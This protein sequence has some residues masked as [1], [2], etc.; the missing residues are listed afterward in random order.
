M[1]REGSSAKNMDALFNI[2]NRIKYWTNESKF[3]NISVDDY[4]KLLK[5]PI[6][7][8]LVSDDKNPIDLKN[9]HL[10]QLIK[11]AINYDIEPIE[12]IKMVTL[13]PANHYHLNSGEIS[14]GKKANF[15]LVNNLKDLN[16]KL[17]IVN[18]E[19]VAKDGKSLFKV[20]KPKVSN[21]FNVNLKKP[22]DFDIKT[23]KDNNVN[24]KIIEAFN[25]ELITNSIIDT[26][27]IENNIIISDTIKDI[28]KISVVERYGHNI[29]SNGFIKGFG[30][31]KGAVAT[32]ISHDSH[33]IITIGTNSI[34]MAKAVNELIQNQGGLTVSY[35]N[36]KKS[37]KLQIAGLMSDESIEIVSTNFE[38]MKNLVRKLG[39]KL[40]DPFMTLSFM[41]LLVIPDLKLSDKGLFSLN[42]FGFVNVIQN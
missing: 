20:K 4:E 33:N 10:N 9:G 42:E 31:K 16:I 34:D 41:A 8:F 1:V 40:D 36:T 15:T 22:E 29:V 24:V 37:L 27:K 19:I 32:S 3:G 17:T 38:N 5:H 2:N 13:N 23:K 28:L 21:T 25:G 14:V 12:A 26:L 6:F 35:N 30:I 39:S 18:G 7:D 11:K